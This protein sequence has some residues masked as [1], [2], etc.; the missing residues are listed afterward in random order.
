MDLK[1]QKCVPCKVGA[2][3]LKGKLLYEFVSQ[4]DDWLLHDKETKMHKEFKFKDFKSAISF[5]N[6]IADLA[7][8]LGHHPNITLFDYN[9]VRIDLWTHKINGLHKNDFILASRIDEI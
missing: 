1:N 7:E 9:K 4:V 3:I 8:E 2:P 6:Q 5:V